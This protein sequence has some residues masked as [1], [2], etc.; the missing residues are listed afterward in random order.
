MI[1]K[2]QNNACLTVGKEAL[3]NPAWREYGHYCLNREKG[4]RRQAF[5]HL[6]SFLYQAASWYDEEEVLALVAEAKEHIAHLRNG[7][8]K[9]DIFTDLLSGEQ[10]LRDWREFKVEGGEEFDQWCKNRGRHYE[11]IK[12]YYYDV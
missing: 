6:E 2:D 9:D 5:S 1:T 7:V 8:R 3:Q 4:L 10:L 12:A 11:W